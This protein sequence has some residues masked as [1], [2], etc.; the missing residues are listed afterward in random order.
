MKPTDKNPV[1]AIQVFEPDT[2]TVYTIE[3]AGHIAQVPR[4]T[5]L[6]Y[7]KHGLVSP[8]VDPECG[9]Y[10]FNDEAIRTLR[11]IEYLR[12]NCGINLGGIKMILRLTNEVE[13]LRA[14]TRFLR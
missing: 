12:T 13:R 8:V 9:G 14:E 3:A 10:Y 1:R 5:I 7:Y 2:N 6:V 4:R 11:R